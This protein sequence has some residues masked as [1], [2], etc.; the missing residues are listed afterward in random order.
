MAAR[1]TAAPPSIPAAPAS[2]AGPGGGGT[3]PSLVV[4]SG[5]PIPGFRPRQPRPAHRVTVATATFG[6]GGPRGNSPSWARNGYVRPGLLADSI[7]VR[8]GW[9]AATRSRAHRR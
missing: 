7:R 9:T 4:I 6:P 5:Q 8:G 1:R 3:L 2:P